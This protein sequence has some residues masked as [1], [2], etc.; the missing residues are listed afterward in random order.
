MKLR[1]TLFSCL[2]LLF[3]STSLSAQVRNCGAT[4]YLEMQQQQDPKR[5]AKLEAIDK[6]AENYAASAE[7]IDGIVTIPVVFHVVYRTATEN[8]SDAQIATQMQVLNDDFR[9]L[10]SDADNTWSQAADSEIE[11]CMA[12]ID[13]NGN[14]TNGITRTATNVNGFGTN[15][16]VKFDSQGGKDA[17]PASDY[18]NIWVCNIGGGIL[19]YAQFPGGPAATDGVV[20]GYQYTGTI[21]T[22]QAPFN[23]GR[24][25]T[26]EV[27]HYL[28]LRHIWGDT[29]CG[30]DDF[31]AD[32]PLSDAANYGC[33]TGHSS[34]GSTDMV[35]NYMD[36]S[37]DA[38]MNLLT[39]GQKTRMRALFDA[40]GFREALA[41]STKCGAPADPT[42]DD[43]VQ[44]GNETGVDCGGDC[45]ACPTC[46]DGVQNGN[47]TGVDCGGDCAVCPC[48]GTNV[49]VTIT[50]DNYPEETS[51]TLT[52]AS[53]NTIGSGGTYGSQPDGSTVSETF[54]L[55]DGCFDFTINDAY[56]DGICC[57]YGSGSY[58]VTDADG[59]VLVSGGNF[60]DSETNNFCVGST[61]PDPTCDD[62]VQ[63][64]NETGVDCGGDC[65]P[66]ATCDDG[67]QN[68]NE[69]GVDCGGDCTACATCND[70]IQNGD[71]TGVDCGGSACIP[72]ATCNDGMQ[73]GNE[74]GVDCGGDC[75]ACDD[76]CDGTNVTVSINLDNYPEE[77]SW[78]LR[79]ANGAVVGSGGTYGNQPDGSNVSDEFCLADGCYEFTIS[80]SY[81]DGICCG[82]GNG[83]YTVYDEFGNVLANGGNFGR[84]ETT[85]FCL[86]DAPTPTCDDGIQNGD[87]TG[88]DCGGSCAPC[89]NGGCTDTQ[90]N[91]NNF[92]SGWGI[93]NDGGSDCRRSS[94]DA[95]FAFSGNRCVRLRDNSG[96]A[97]SMTT[98]NLNLANFEEV[99]IDFTYIGNSMETG[100]DFWLQVSTNGGASYQTIETWARGTDFQ[101][102][103]REFETVTMTGNF[104]SNTRF[105]LRCDASANADQV[106]IDDVLLTGCAGNNLS[107]DNETEEVTIDATFRQPQQA[108]ETAVE[109][110]IG[111]LKLFP[112]P[113]SDV[114]SVSYE[115]NTT[116]D[117]TLIVTDLTGRVVMQ[118]VQ[119]GKAGKQTA[120][121]TVSD[122]HAGIYLLQV[123]SEDSRLMQKF[124]VVR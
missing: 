88:V 44:N 79:D 48:D 46:D 94:N 89:D 80:D 57:Q 85:E 17:W 73:N 16:A 7:K 66:C 9:R 74:T 58:A 110:A 82:Y 51:W 4:D 112:N 72:C 91:F 33:A 36:Y 3:F 60:G 37:D 30:G 28:N 14:P 8:I 124:V 120:Q 117:V 54:C 99:T 64:G 25:L 11:F 12:T 90:I 106:Y 53:G 19:G 104:S 78:V 1:Y 41:N 113:T 63:N 20:N 83:A 6:H 102:G 56:G 10:N 70:G 97:S 32:T 116:A 76:G 29:G 61:E 62:G 34:C 93:W 123:I 71:E 39:E 67:V 47:E 38:C 122:Q 98:D 96:T 31:V 103:V 121:F 13:P 27:G 111:K 100:E 84:N 108:E 115:M 105:R 65:A 2:M 43:G 107:P 26:H 77:T 52:D 59:N 50:L 18:L 42:C 92:D 5:A 87:E 24:T 68:G 23:G 40:G 109:A 101:N 35:Q 69:T 55:T 86:G 15:D 22:A 81:G 114:L 118:Q 95:A 119:A 49:T 75:P 45:A 21:G